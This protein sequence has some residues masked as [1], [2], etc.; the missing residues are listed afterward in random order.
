MERKFGA[1]RGALFVLVVGLGGL[2]AFAKSA[3]CYV[4]T[5]TASGA[6]VRWNG[7]AKLNLAGNPVNQVGLSEDDFFHAVVKGLQRWQAAADGTVSFDYWQ[8]TD[9]S[10]YEPDSNFNGLSSIY[11]LSHTRGGGTLSPNILGLTQVWYNSNTGQ[12]L[13][14][15]IVLNDVDFHFTTDPTDTSGYGSPSAP[16]GKPGGIP[17]V[18]I[19]NVVTHELGHA[20]GLSHAGGLQSTMLFM[21]SPDQAHLSCDEQVGIHALYPSARDAQSGGIKGKVVTSSG[22]GVFGAHVVAISRTRG[23][24]L[25]A[26]MTDPSGNYSLNALEPGT[27]YLMAE[28]YYAGPQ[29]LPSYYSRINAAI[30][31][32]GA[33]FS[34][35]F[36]ADA[37]GYRLNG[38]TVESGRSVGAPQMIAECSP[39]TKAQIGIADA[40]VANDPSIDGAGFAIAARL[41]DTSGG[42][43]YKVKELSGHVEIHAL[44]FSLYSPIH[45]NISLLDANGRPVAAR[46]YDRSY[47]SESG[48]IDYDSYLVADGLEPGDYYVSFQGSPQSPSLY[49]AAP[50]S[51]DANPFFVITGSVNEPAPLFADTLPN[52]A[53]CREDENF[54]DYK[55]PSGNPPR[56]QTDQSSNSG[57]GFCA[58]LSRN[59]RGSNGGNGSGPGAGAIVGWFVPWLLMGLFAS[60]SKLRL[61]RARA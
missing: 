29:T 44:N 46:E 53:R 39:M 40:P 47:E 35:T 52:T 6:G 51:L 33:L 58:T 54:P 18:F 8:G 24:A 7:N 31:P 43:F 3:F 61:R 27:Y 12:I 17:N 41:P 57:V 37:S 21:E 2:G 16:A 50:I 45:G 28:P 22:A 1:V 42:V 14:T 49:P 34:R 30:C 38:L 59:D 19:E 56:S 10:I 20:L 23:T 4:P 48:Y 26:A 15:D 32:S 60:I 25:A 11:F 55:S 9:D 5:L 13:E 36:L